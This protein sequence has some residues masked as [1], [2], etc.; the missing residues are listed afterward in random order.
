MKVKKRTLWLIIFCT[1]IFILI[2]LA[3]FNTAK[4]QN[5][6][7]D[8]IQA[9]VANDKNCS[10]F[11]DRQSAQ[12]HFEAL[13]IIVL[14][15][16]VQDPHS[17]DADDNGYACEGKEYVRWLKLSSDTTS[18]D[19]QIR[20]VET[21]HSV[22]CD[23]IITGWINITEFSNKM[24]NAPFTQIEYMPSMAEAE[25]LDTLFEVYSY[26]PE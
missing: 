14:G 9:F 20:T 1:S 24:Q 4:A 23:P 15:E 2:I 21:V 16:G 5:V 19:L 3:G 11:R 12:T 6:S 18:W 25:C 17:L 8:S 22:K 10:D 13:E 26:N 7:I